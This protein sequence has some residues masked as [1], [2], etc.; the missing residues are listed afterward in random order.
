MRVKPASPPNGSELLILNKDGQMLFVTRPQVAQILATTGQRSKPLPSVLTE[1]T[2][3][4]V[5]RA[6]QGG[7][8][9]EFTLADLTTYLAGTAQP[10]P[11]PQGRDLTVYSGRERFVGRQGTGV[12]ASD[13]LQTLYVRGMGG[14]L[15]GLGGDTPDNPTPTPTPTPTP[16]DTMPNAFAFTAQTDA[17]RSSVVTS[18]AVTVSGIDAPAPISVTGG[19]YQIGSG[20]WTTANGTVTNGQSVRVRLTSSSSYNTVATATL[21][22]G[23]VSDAFSVTTL[24]EPVVTPPPTPAAFT[25]TQLAQPN[26]IYQRQ[27]IS[28]G[29]QGAGTGTIPLS[30]NVSTSGALYARIRSDDGTTILQPAYLLNS[31]VATGAQTINVTGIDARVGWFYVDLSGDKTTWTNGTTPVG[32]GVLGVIAGQSLSVRI[33]RKY[34]DATNI[35]AAGATISPYTRIWGTADGN[36]AQPSAW[37]LPDDASPTN[38]TGAGA[39]QLMSKLVG[40]AGCNVGLVTQTQGATAIAAWLPGQTLG[41][42]LLSTMA[43]A[44]GAFEFVYWFQGHSDSSGA[45][46]NQTYK[47]RLTTLF[48]AIGAANNYPSPVKLISSIPNIN[49]TSW[50]T[51]LQKEALRTASY[52]WALANGAI[53]VVMSD[54]SMIS[55][56]IHQDQ[57]GS[58]RTGQHVYRA[59]RPHFRAAHGDQ[60]ITLGQPT[61]SD[62]SIT[63]PYTL[64]PGATAPVTSGAPQS[65]FKV[66]TAADRT[67]QLALD[68]T[69]PFTIDNVAKTF[70]IKL[71]SAPG[72]VPIQI[73][74]LGANDVANDGSTNNIYDDVLDS[75]GITYGRG[76]FASPRAMKIYPTTS[77]NLT[78]GGNPTYGTGK[79]GNTATAGYGT[80]TI[81]AQPGLQTGFTVECW[82]NVMDA[83]NARV[84]FGVG[85]MH[86]CWLG[87]QGNDLKVQ[88]GSTAI[89]TFT[90]VLPSNTW[91]HIAVTMDGNGTVAT[92]WLDGVQLGTIA[93][94]RTG[95]VVYDGSNGWGIRRFGANTTYD[96]TTALIDEVALFEGVRYTGTF[97]PPTNPYVGNEDGL[98]ALFHLDGDF[99]NSA[100]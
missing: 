9:V 10:D 36:G 58:I 86:G 13:I 12:F 18:N 49:S 43:S 78:A 30:I 24:A 100:I 50:G 16:S 38:M 93:T 54:L 92:I 75:D 76:I 20:S 82:L 46:P 62:V 98:V 28:G 72:N 11:V 1:R 97:T 3:L 96:M 83:P 40:V 74:P 47:D 81:P 85:G 64:P 22:V 63:I 4:E 91:K 55:D 25:M 42:A 32:M 37:V 19:E 17:A 67:T 15:A 29:G 61:I 60:G 33:F 90:G 56:G 87:H 95:Y 52:E 59:L 69:T 73:V 26:R 65:L 88:V 21:T 51:L 41:N 14:S 99:N 68:A 39:A 35:V 23:G 89:S 8:L 6:V 31:S 79:F 80:V 2:G 53:P 48:N 57:A 45:T 84:Y 71:A 70:T 34:T 5:Y 66:Y 44:G 77:R 7:N 27:T 94:A